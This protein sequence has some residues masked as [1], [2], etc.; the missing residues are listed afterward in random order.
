L[1]IPLKDG[2]YFQSKNEDNIAQITAY[3]VRY[4]ILE[5]N[6]VNILPKK[7]N[8]NENTLTVVD[9]VIS[10]ECEPKDSLEIL[11]A[12]KKVIVVPDG[13]IYDVYKKDPV[14]AGPFYREDFGLSSITLSSEFTDSYYYG[15]VQIEEVEVIEVPMKMQHMNQ[16]KNN[17]KA[18]TIL[19][20]QEILRKEKFQ[21]R[22]ST[23]KRSTR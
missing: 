12:L 4:S 7:L 5:A 19:K 2:W 22:T 10:I 17:P 14:S 1:E 20:L 16:L 11:R 6:S 8:I 15:D 13:S 21:N 23:I 3:D 18:I 9:N